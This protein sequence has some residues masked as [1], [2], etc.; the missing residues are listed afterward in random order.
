MDFLILNMALLA[1]LIL[2]AD[3]DLL[4]GSSSSRFVGLGV[5]VVGHGCIGWGLA[6]AV[7]VVLLCLSV[8]VY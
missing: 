6:V 1:G 7:A 3:G 2:D 4:V 5:F 8:S